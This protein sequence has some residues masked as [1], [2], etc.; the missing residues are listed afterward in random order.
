MDK[1]TI[2]ELECILEDDAIDSIEIL[3]NGEVRAYSSISGKR[4]TPIQITTYS[5]REL[6]CTCNEISAL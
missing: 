2:Q 6:L 3:P 5:L 4:P 1:P